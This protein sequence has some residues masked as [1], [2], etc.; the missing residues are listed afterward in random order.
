MNHQEQLYSQFNKFPKV[1]IEKK[2][3]EV[4]NEDVKVL[5]QVEKNISDYYRSTLI[6]LINEKRIEGKLI[7]DTAELRYDYFNNVL[8]KNGDI[9]EEIEERFPTISQRVII[10]IEQYLDLL[11]C[12]KKHF[13]I[14][15]S[16]LKKIKFICSDDEYPNLNNLDIKV[17]GD[18]HNGSGVCILSYEGQKLVYKKKSSKPN[19]LLKKLDNQV[20]KYLKKEIQFVP[21][22]LDREGYFWETFIDSKPVCSIDEAKEFYKRMGYLVAYAYILNISD[23]H[24]ENLISHNVQPILVDAETVFS[25]SPYETVADNNATLEIIRDSRNSV[26]STGLLPVSE[27]DK[28]F[29]GD[30][31]GVLGGT[32]IGEA[33]VLI[34]QNRDDIHV[35]K[36]KYKTENQAHL[37][38]RVGQTGLRNYLNAEDYIDSIKMGY[39]ELGHF[40]I[41]NKEFLKQ[42]YLSFSDLKTRV[43]FRNTRDYS[44]VR[45]L[46]TSPIYCNQ[47]NVLFEKM[48]DKLSNFESLNLCESEEKQLLNMNIPYFYSR[49]SDVDIKDNETIVWK[50]KESALTEALKKL[51]RFDLSIMKEQVDLIEFSIKTPNALYST[52]LQES[53]KKFNNLNSDKEVLF[54]GI[55]T[56]VDTILYN[57]KCSKLDGSTNWLTLKVTDYDAFKL[58]PMDLS[59]YEGISGLSIALCEVYDLVNSERQEK[60]YNCIHRIFLTLS[61]SYDNVQNQSYYVGK[62]GILSALKRIQLITGQKIS[63]SILDRN[64]DYSLDLNVSSADFLS[65]FPNEIV[66]LYRSDLS[67]K[68]LRQAL[69]KLIDLKV[70]YENYIAWDNLESNNVSL[71]HGNLGIE[72][73]LHYIAGILDNSKALEMLFQAN[74]FDNRQKISQGWIDKRNNSTSANWCHGSTGVLVARLAQLEL[75]KKFQLIPSARRKELEADIRHAVSQIIEVGF[76]MTNFSICHGTSGNLLA[77][78]YYRSYLKGHEAQELEKILEIEYRKLHSFGLENGWMCSFNTKYNV[79]GIMNGLSGILYSTAKY[80]KR[81]NSL[82]LLIPTL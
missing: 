60:I 26:L 56:L 70:N 67:I 62:L 10:S 27:A 34:N 74:N 9:L 55:N 13:S 42:L 24:F 78:N 75:D 36:Q 73:A 64:K 17:T 41:D 39:L 65:S 1:F 12:V 35:E 51:E 68:N 5:K 52:E 33:R 66:A 11:K 50:L 28:I 21:D 29:G 54:A 25:V 46:L 23:L 31:S 71:A 20:S 4:L 61:N 44:L 8:C 76:N 58:E 3:P 6:Y 57:E 47:S 53:Y 45:Q 30:T 7:G 63:K 32:L 48:S 72:L 40:I 18:I 19:H 59:I 38:Y 49:I 43:L 14:D 79:Y 69:D 15:F 81:D 22:F 82:D 37:P 77:L 80:L 2:I 16:I